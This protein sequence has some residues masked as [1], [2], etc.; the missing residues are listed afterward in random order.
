[1]GESETKPDL[2]QLIG[3]ANEGVE[4]HQASV[5]A[6]ANRRP[7]QSHAKA[8]FA[9]VLMA[10]CV[11]MALLQYPRI[12]APYEWPDAD[13]SSE[14]AEA[15]LEA[16]VAAIEGYRSAQG[17]YPAS[18]GLVSIPEGLAPVVASTKLDYAPGDNAYTLTWSL[19]HWI[20]RYSSAAGKISVERQ[21][22][23]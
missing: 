18:L 14:A 17:Q 20:A 21:A 15:D 3:A 1:M 6:L 16:V 22:K 23:H 9:Y 19:P 10:G 12:Q 7:A 11:A 8:A 5:A 2:K 4:Q 13:A